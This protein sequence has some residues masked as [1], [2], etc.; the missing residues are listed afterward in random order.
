MRQVY[1]D[2]AAATP[3]KP[4]V[5]A[6]MKPYLTE[7][8]YNPSAPYLPAVEVRRS[9][10]QAKSTI[11]QA[12]GAKAD[13]L[14]MT[15]G[16]TE[17]INLAFSQTKNVIISGVEHAAVVATAQS[18]S[19]CEVLPVNKFGLVEVNRLTQLIHPET[20]L[21][22]VSLV[23][24]DLGTIQP[25][26]E[27]SEIIKQ[28]RLERSLEGN[29]T[30]LWLHCDASQALSYLEVNV[31]RLGVDMLTLS[32]AKIGGPKQVGALWVRPTVQ[33]SPVIYGGGQ[34]LGLRSG[35]ENVAGVIGFAKA[36]ELITRGRAKEVAKRRDQLA[37]ILL[38]LPGV[39]IIGHSKKRLPNYLVVSFGDIEADRL[40]YRLEKRGIYVSTGSACA[41]NRGTGSLALKSI[42]LSE[43]QQLASLR[44]T[45]GEQTTADDIAYAGQIITNEV[46]LERERAGK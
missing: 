41:A 21:V 10:E 44:L 1:L 46:K 5:L 28:I 12:I 39:K 25:L 22:S 6:A 17:S 8:F 7:L 33:L 40:I 45:L 36:I 4:K 14:I 27:I 13:Q 32:A 30:P 31:A 23:S 18:K 29:Q 42:G 9:Y 20:D 11:A 24:S 43:T 34:E 3:L 19:N 37:K 15:A 2:Y 35:T 38:Q 16:A 26:R